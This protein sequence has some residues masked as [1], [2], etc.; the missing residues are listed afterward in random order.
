MLSGV[1]RTLVIGDPA[2]A[3]TDIGPVISED[4]Q[5]S[6]MEHVE[7]MGR[8]ARD[9]RG[10]PAGQATCPWLLRRSSSDRAQRPCAARKRAVWPPAACG[11][12]RANELESLLDAIRRTGYG[13][14]LGVQTRLESTWRWVSAGTSAGNIYINRN[15]IGAVVGVQPFG[16]NGLSGTGPKAGGPHY[17]PRLASERT[18][19]INTTATG[20]NSESL[21][22]ARR[23]WLDNR[24]FVVPTRQ[25]SSADVPPILSSRRL[26]RPS[27]RHRHY[28]FVSEN[29]DAGLPHKSSP[30]I[31]G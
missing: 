14:T 28:Q 26:A 23:C 5:R 11:V 27:S 24:A 18:L 13:L 12:Y 3:H 15:M 8:E 31:V 6:L 1:M 29:H 21:R 2:E 22:L 7:H 17:L 16:G 20:G 19:T 9:T 30:T 10:L 25:W 4:A